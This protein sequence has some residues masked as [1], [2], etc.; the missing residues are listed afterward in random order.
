MRFCQRPRGAVGLEPF[1]HGTDILG[2]GKPP[3]ING[4]FGCQNGDILE[5]INNHVVAFRH[6]ERSVHRSERDRAALEIAPLVVSSSFPDS[7]PGPQVRLVDRCGDN[8]GVIGLFKK[9]IVDGD[10]GRRR[11]RQTIKT[12]KIKIFRGA[13]D[14]LLDSGDDIRRMRSA[15]FQKVRR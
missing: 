9:R 15:L 1:D 8:G 7:V 13:G 6:N 3:D 10:V 5:P 4:V 12:Q 14:R 2:R 11:E